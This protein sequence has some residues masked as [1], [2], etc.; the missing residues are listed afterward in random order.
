LTA[1]HAAFVAPR[2]PDK[3]DGPSLRALARTFGIPPVDAE[4]AATL[5]HWCVE[6]DAAEAAE[7]LDRAYPGAPRDEEGF[8]RYILSSGTCG[9]HDPRKDPELFDVSVAMARSLWWRAV[10]HIAKW[11]AFQGEQRA[12]VEHSKLM[13]REAA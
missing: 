2:P 13:V 7:W 8:I 1:L 3:E 6:R 4:R 5:G 10:S 9:L 12:R 11:E